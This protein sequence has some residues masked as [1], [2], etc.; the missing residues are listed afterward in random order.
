MTDRVCVVCNETRNGMT[1]RLT[2][3]KGTSDTC[4]LCYPCD[5]QAQDQFEG[6]ETFRMMD[7]RLYKRTPCGCRVDP[8]GPYSLSIAGNCP[9][10]GRYFILKLKSPLILLAECVD[11]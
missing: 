5:A 6:R 10:R 9:C 8:P 3:G 7:I 4:W 1:I 2:I 11:G